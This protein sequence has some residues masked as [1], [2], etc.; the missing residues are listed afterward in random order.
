MK[1]I[2]IITIVL[3]LFLAGCSSAGSS[4]NK[5]GLAQL[6]SIASST[7]LAAGTDGKL[8]GKAQAD[9]TMCAVMVDAAGKVIDIKIDVAQTAINFDDKGVITTDKTA[10]VKSKREKG[11]DYGMIKASKIGREWFEE[12]DAIQKWMIGKTAD[13][14]KG[15]KV[16]VSA[17]EGGNISAEPDLVSSATLKIDDF[18]T[19]AAKAIADAT[20]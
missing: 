16:A 7:D 5:L 19:I 18:I 12:V 1:K 9:T 20:K 8:I 2:F 15:M 17:A 4:A 11:A 10:E 13:Q 6:T 3:L 14:I